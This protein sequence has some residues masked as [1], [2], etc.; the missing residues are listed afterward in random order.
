MSLDVDH[1]GAVSEAEAAVA[2][3]STLGNSANQR[4]PYAEYVKGL[5][6]LDPK[7]EAVSKSRFSSAAHDVFRS[8]DTDGDGLVSRKELLD[9]KK[10][11]RDRITSRPSR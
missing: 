9:Y 10:A 8:I 11:A 4:V 3:S 6:E 7:S 1:D 2:S 5:L